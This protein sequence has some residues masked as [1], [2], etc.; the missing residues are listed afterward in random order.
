MFTLGDDFQYQ[1][2]VIFSIPKF[3]ASIFVHI[4]AKDEQLTPSIQIIWHDIS[5]ILIFSSST[6][7]FFKE[8]NFYSNI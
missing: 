7:S 3:K 4:S 2:A 8:G 1:N 5:L 6:R